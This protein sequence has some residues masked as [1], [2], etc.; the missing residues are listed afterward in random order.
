LMRKMMLLGCTVEGEEL[1]RAGAFAEYVA[2]DR[3]IEVA[4]ELAKQLAAKHP[5]VMRQMKQSLV[6]VEDMS[7]TASYRIE[8]KYAVMIPAAV[9]AELV[10]RPSGSSR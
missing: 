10:P 3:V 5:V 9:R 8:Q 1:N 7:V 2:D 4:G 6:E